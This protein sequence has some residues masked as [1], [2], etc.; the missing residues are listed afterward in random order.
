[1]WLY[2]HGKT[3]DQKEQYLIQNG[4]RCCAILRGSITSLEA[5]GTYMTSLR[6]TKIILY[7]RVWLMFNRV[8]R[9]FYTESFL[10]LSCSW[11]V[12]LTARLVPIEAVFKLLIFRYSP[13]SVVRLYTFFC[14]VIICFATTF[15]VS[16]KVELGSVVVLIAVNWMRLGEIVRISNQTDKRQRGGSGRRPSWMPSACSIQSSR[17]TNYYATMAIC[18]SM[19]SVTN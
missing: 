15:F 14:G 5:F 7:Y 6:A 18:N 10:F 3:W 4:S 16:I 19:I 11:H 1:M 2:A 13:V 9:Y 17:C 8:A 12:P